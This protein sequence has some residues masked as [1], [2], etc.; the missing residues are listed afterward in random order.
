MHIM[1]NI[2]FLIR[3]F[4]ISFQSSGYRH[5]KTIKFNILFLTLKGPL[6]I[7]IS[8][9]NGLTENKQIYTYLSN[10]KSIIL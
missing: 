4:L 3:L 10:I 7:Q 2:I 9:T 1:N 5:I 6:Y 8:L